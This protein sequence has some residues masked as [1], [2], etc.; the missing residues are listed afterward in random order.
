MAALAAGFQP[1]ALRQAGAGGS[2]EGLLEG[3]LS[4]ELSVGTFALSPPACSLLSRAH[5]SWTDHVS[6]EAVCSADGLGAPAVGQTMCTGQ[7]PT[8]AARLAGGPWDRPGCGVSQGA[9]GLPAAPSTVRVP[10]PLARP[11]QRASFSSLASC[12]LQTS[13]L[14]SGLHPCR[15]WPSSGSAAELRALPYA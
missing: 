2:S 8:W 1:P 4:L 12:P 5:D 7:Q 11:V 10:P 13:F 6:F 3:G 15:I 14:P 9:Q